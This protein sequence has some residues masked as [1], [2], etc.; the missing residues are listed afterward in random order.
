MG[1]RSRSPINWVWKNI[2]AREADLQWIELWNSI[3]GQ[4]R[5]SP[6]DRDMEEYSK[7]WTMFIQWS[8]WPIEHYASSID[9]VNT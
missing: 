8:M 5:R 3:M 7:K 4:K 1:Q 2:V 6:M 9:I